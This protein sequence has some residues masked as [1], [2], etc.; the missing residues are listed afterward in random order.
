MLPN[1]K[2][3]ILYF[4]CLPVETESM[5]NMCSTQDAAVKNLSEFCETT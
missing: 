2:G 3:V 5:Q 1:F 4:S